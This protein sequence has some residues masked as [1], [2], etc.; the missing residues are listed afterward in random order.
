MRTVP[1]FPLGSVLFPS[2][3]LSLRIFEPRYVD[4]VSRC[5]RE[6]IGF[7]VI[8]LVDGPAV[9]RAS[10]YAAAIGTEARI[11]DFNR[12][13][14]GLLGIR[15]LGANRVRVLRSWREPDGLNMGEVIDVP[16]QEVVEIPEPHSYLVDILRRVYP[17]LAEAYEG[18]EPRWQEAGWVANRLAEIAPLDAKVRQRLLEQLDPIERLRFIGPLIRM[19]KTDA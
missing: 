1:L 4:M 9:D 15:C 10:S 13:E 11:V 7:V 18:V 5:L 8:L 16:D 2:G 17:E 6:Q 3:P 19:A 14:D 12:L